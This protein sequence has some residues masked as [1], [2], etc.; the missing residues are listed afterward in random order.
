MS[1]NKFNIK[2]LR[3]IV[4][5]FL[6]TAAIQSC[7]DNAEEGSKP[8]FET[9]ISYEKISTITAQK[10]QTGFSLLALAFP[11][12]NSLNFA[13]ANDVNIY[14]VKYRTTL[15]SEEI[16]ASGLVCLPVKKGSYPILSFQNGT[17]T[18]NSRAPSV[19]ISDEQ[20]VILENLSG[21]GYIITIPD[22]VGFGESNEILHPYYHR[23]SSDAAVINLIKASLEM[24]PAESAGSITTGNFS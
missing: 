2:S 15:N 21:L 18:S 23:Q 11:E 17:N 5:L 1:I 10:I 24:L 4:I 14:K 13:G 9:L 16:V 8:G 20:F 3:P 6:V 19:N 12:I 22:Y 7:R